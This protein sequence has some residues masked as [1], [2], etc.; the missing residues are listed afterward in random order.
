[1]TKT[2]KNTKSWLVVLDS[3]FKWAEMC[4]N[5]F[6][7]CKRHFLVR[8]SA[9]Q[10]FFN[11]NWDKFKISNLLKDK[12]AL[13]FKNGKMWV[14][15]GVYL[16]SWKNKWFKKRINI[17]VFHKNGLK[18]PSVLATSADISDIYDNMIKKNWEKSFEKKLEE[19][20]GK[21]SV[22]N[23]ENNVFSAFVELYKKRWTIEECFKELKSY[24]SFEKF[25]V[26]SHDAIIKYLHIILLVHTLTYIML[27]SLTQ[28][29][30]N[31]NFVYDFL[32]EKRNI[33]NEINWIKKITFMWV[34]L[35]IEMMFQLW[36]SWNLKW[37]SK[38]RLKNILKNSICLKSVSFDRIGLN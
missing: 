4:K 13:Q 32:K 11:Q 30:N 5:I 9:T 14:F 25:Q 17:I 27:F 3:G 10:I 24:L 28:S 23:F 2:I 35:F 8:I 21:I 33:K 26:Q 29:H 16:Q 36:W 1:M 34:K 19:N 20:K 18:N 12:N 15:K 22:I 31:F 6:E 37:K 38:R 7:N